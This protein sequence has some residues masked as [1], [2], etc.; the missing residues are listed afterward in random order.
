VKAENIGLF[1][2]PKKTGKLRLSRFDYA[3]ML[4]SKLSLSPCPMLASQTKFSNSGNSTI[5]APSALQ[6]KSSED[7][8]H[9]S[10]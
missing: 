7:P 9:L 4:S 5:F 2:P 10:D 6:L 1:Q 3:L 8:F